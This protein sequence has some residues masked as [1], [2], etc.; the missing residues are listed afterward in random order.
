M[1]LTI[2]KESGPAAR[3]ATQVV[4]GTILFAIVLLAAFGL[5]MLL[6]WMES[7]GAPEWMITGAHWVEWAVFWVDVFLFS[8][9][10]L[11]EAIRFVIGLVQE[12]KD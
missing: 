2:P 10:L 1:A 8:L 6:K 3:F 9:F 5:A 11:S 4:V 12:W 7:L